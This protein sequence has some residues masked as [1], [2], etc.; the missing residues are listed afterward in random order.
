MKKAKSFLTCVLVAISVTTGLSDN[1]GPNSGSGG[2]GNNMGGAAETWVYH[3]HGNGTYSLMLVT[4]GSFAGHAA[5]G[6]LWP[7]T[8]CPISGPKVCY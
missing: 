4:A 2:N 6:D 7:Y 5:H 1:D 3:A 8:V